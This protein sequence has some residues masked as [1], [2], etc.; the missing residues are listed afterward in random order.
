MILSLP[1]K[2]EHNSRCAVNYFLTDRKIF[3]LL[4]PQLGIDLSSRP[5]NDKISDPNAFTSISEGRQQVLVES[6]FFVS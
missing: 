5:F 2:Q 4:A 3:Q 6:L 1:K